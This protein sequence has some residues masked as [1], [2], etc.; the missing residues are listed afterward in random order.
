M[1]IFSVLFQVFVC[2]PDGSNSCRAG[3]LLATGNIHFVWTAGV[4]A[5]IAE[6]VFTRRVLV[7]EFTENDVHTP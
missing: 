4:S 2:I 3:S 5:D 7:P 6:L 1:L